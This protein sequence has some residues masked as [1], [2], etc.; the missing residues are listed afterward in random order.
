MD[1]VA[2]CG[3]SVAGQSLYAL[4]MVDVATGWIACTGLRDKRQEIVFDA[5]LERIRAAA[6]P[7]LADLY[8]AQQAMLRSRRG[9]VAF[10]AAW[11]DGAGMKLRTVDYAQET[12][13]NL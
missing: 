1:L 6:W 4:S 11:A 8:A 12:E 10:Q 2:D 9:A 5:L 7:V 3:W 13:L